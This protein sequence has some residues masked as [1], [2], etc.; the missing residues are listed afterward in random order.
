MCW[1]HQPSLLHCPGQDNSPSSPQ[2]RVPRGLSGPPRGL[3][4]TLVTAV[5]GT[6]GAR[7]TVLV[8]WP[9][10]AARRA[11][12]GTAVPSARRGPQTSSHIINWAQISFSLREG[13][14]FLSYLFELCITLGRLEAELSDGKMNRINSG[15]TEE[16]NAAD[17]GRGAALSR[18]SPLHWRGRCSFCLDVPWMPT[19]AEEGRSPHLP[20]TAVAERGRVGRQPKS[21]GRTVG[22]AEIVSALCLCPARI[23]AVTNVAGRTGQ[24]TAT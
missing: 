24:T 7:Q 6:A 3:R 5:E 19:A 14:F 4:V 2:G 13:F 16:R 21:E 11:C 8:V 23:R 1:S 9:G 17:L 10:S 12:A 18:R 20:V 22:G 15:K